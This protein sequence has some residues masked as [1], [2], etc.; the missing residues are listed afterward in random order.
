VPPT[1]VVTAAGVDEPTS[2]PRPLK[3][4]SST[5]LLGNHEAPT[6]IPNLFHN[7]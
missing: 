4:K 7:D 5:T 6:L 2:A 1:N 3:R